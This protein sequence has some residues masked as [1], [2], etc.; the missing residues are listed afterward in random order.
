MTPVCSLPF[1]RH[2]PNN[3]LL[4]FE[5]ITLIGRQ[6]QDESDWLFEFWPGCNRVLRREL[7]VSG[8]EVRRRVLFTVIMFSLLSVLS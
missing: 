8:S 2:H 3:Q 1:L 4:F 5:L 7:L 6:V